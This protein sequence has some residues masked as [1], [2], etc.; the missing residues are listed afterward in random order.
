MHRMKRT[1]WRDFQWS[2]PFLNDLHA[3]EDDRSIL[4]S[5]SAYSSAGVTSTLT[6]MPWRMLSVTMQKSSKTSLH[7]SNL[8]RSSTTGL[9]S[10]WIPVMRRR[11]SLVPFHLGFHQRGHP[12][13]FHPR[14]AEAE[15]Q[16]R[17]QAIAGCG[18]KKQSRIGILTLP[19][20]LRLI[21]QQ[22][23][24]SLPGEAHL[25]LI[26]LQH[27]DANLAGLLLDGHAG[28][29]CAHWFKLFKSD[30]SSS[31]GGSSSFFGL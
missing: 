23:L 30:R 21:H 26:V 6:G 25:E 3:C 7:I 5:R 28:M 13:Q 29:L 31:I 15:A 8:F 16:R 20:R 10:T 1:S 2:A 18:R 27:L 14:P 12:F 24:Q 17:R 11:P 9:S 19:H 4:Q 22:W